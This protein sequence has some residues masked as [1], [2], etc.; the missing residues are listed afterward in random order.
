MFHPFVFFGQL[1]DSSLEIAATSIRMGA[2]MHWHQQHFE[3]KRAFNSAFFFPHE[4]MTE[5]QR[6]CEKDKYVL[7]VSRSK[8][9]R[10]S[11]AR[12]RST[13]PAAAAAAA[14]AAM[15]LTINVTFCVQY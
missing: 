3:N 12:K 7:N 10:L 1:R 5:A 9:R 8:R 14:A 6:Y 2:G 4:N 11:A 13:G 15:K